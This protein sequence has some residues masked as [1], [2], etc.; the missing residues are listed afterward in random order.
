MSFSIRIQK[1]TGKNRISDAD[2]HKPIFSIRNLHPKN[3]EWI[4]KITLFRCQYDDRNFCTKFGD[5]WC[6][7]V[8]RRLFTGRQTI[9]KRRWLQ[10]LRSWPIAEVYDIII[11][12]PSA[13]F[14]KVTCALQWIQTPIIE[15]RYY[16]LPQLQN[17]CMSYKLEGRWGFYI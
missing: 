13:F 3:I 7:I 17:S 4:N 16:S 8:A 2:R 15:K 14:S 9:H 12:L 11:V 5:D 1:K 6:W 10:Y